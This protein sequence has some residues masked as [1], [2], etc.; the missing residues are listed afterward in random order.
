M[1]RYEIVSRRNDRKEYVTSYA[2]WRGSKV[3]DEPSDDRGRELLKFHLDI[4]D[5]SN[6]STGQVLE[7][8]LEIK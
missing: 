3:F 1:T 2:E 8:R 4:L 7:T 5:K 6:I